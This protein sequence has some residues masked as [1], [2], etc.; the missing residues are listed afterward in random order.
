M[1]CISREYLLLRV[2]KWQRKQDSLARPMRSEMIQQQHATSQID[3]QL[4]HFP[5]F[6]T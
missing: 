3:K 6:Y 5:A 4:M 1:N 2:V